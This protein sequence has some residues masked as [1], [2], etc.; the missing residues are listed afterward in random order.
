MFK[1]NNQVQYRIMMAFA[2]IFLLSAWFYNTPVEILEG[3]QRIVV[4]PS[5]LLSDYFAIGNIGSALLNAGLLMW[6]AIIIALINQVKLS[7]AVVAAFFTIAGFALFGKNI[8]NV[9][10]I[11]GGVWIYA[12]YQ[13]ESFSKFIVIAFFATALSPL[14]SQV[15]FGFGWDLSI[16]LPLATVFGLMAGF[17]FPPLAS[18]FV[19]FHQGYNIYNIGFTSGMVGMV[20]MALFR[21]VGLN[22]PATLYLSSGYNVI[23]ALYLSVYFSIML[24]IGVLCSSDLTNALVGIFKQSGRLVSD[25][26]S[27]DGFGPT[28]VNMG[29]L[30]MVSTVYVLLVRGDL[31]GPALGGIFTIV[32]F[33]A[34]GK[35]VRNILPIL[36]G[37]YISTLFNI[38]EPNTPGAIL[39]A[40]FGTTLA[41]IAGTYG[42]LSGLV[43]GFLHMAIVMGVGTLHGGM[44]LYNNGFSGGFVA[45][46][47]V[48][49]LDALKR[50]QNT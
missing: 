29:L 24:I 28:L 25:Y 9:W 18:H 16:A 23:L 5:I 11:L 30:G 10:P 37:V 44:N 14:V 15:A 43:A 38:W 2:S 6:I 12:K 47:L 39:A 32:G 4:S 17:M 34:F 36:V 42:T 48:P 13:R 49:I 21:S 35:H 27:N 1:P 20:F 7:G 3:Y 31:T 45:A 46:I 33:G 22:N 41:P 40:L 19:R 8:L 26:L 50:N